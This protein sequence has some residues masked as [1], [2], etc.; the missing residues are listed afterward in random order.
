LV[1]KRLLLL[2]HLLNQPCVTTP[3]SVQQR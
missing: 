1:M 2:L 3:S